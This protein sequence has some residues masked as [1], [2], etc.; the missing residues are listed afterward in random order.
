VRS[1]AI[2]VVLHVF[3]AGN[4]D[5]RLERGHLV[6]RGKPFSPF[7]IL[8]RFCESRVHSVVGPI[9]GSDQFQGRRVQA[10]SPRRVGKG[11]RNNDQTF[12]LSSITFVLSSSATTRCFGS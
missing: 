3:V 11:E 5:A 9:A 6:E 12:P 10:S 2:V 8:V 7:L 4:D 1:R